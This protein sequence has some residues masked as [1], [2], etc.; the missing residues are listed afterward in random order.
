MPGLARRS[1]LAAPL[2]IAPATGRAAARAIPP[3]PLWIGRTALLRG[4]AGA[5]RLLLAED[6]TGLMSVR[7]LFLCYALPVRSWRVEEDGMSVVYSRVSALDSSRLIHGEAHI[8]H[9]ENQLLLIEAAR[10]LATFE[11][12]AE[13]GLA[14]SCG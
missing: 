9:A 2:L 8:L 5:A 3:F 14:R 4:E 10:H 11:G 12:F 13:A 6:G 1:L 7:L